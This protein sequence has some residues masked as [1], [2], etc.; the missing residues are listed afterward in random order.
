MQFHKITGGIGVGQKLFECGI[1][2]RWGNALSLLS[3]HILP[4]WQ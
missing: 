4:S 3:R 2:W 1:V